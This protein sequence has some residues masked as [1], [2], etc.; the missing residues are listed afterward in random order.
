MK[1]INVAIIGVGS[2]SKALV[3]G[4]SFYTKNPNE[5]TGLINPT[6]GN[7]KIKDINFVS[8]LPAYSPPSSSPEGIET[9]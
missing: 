1:I 4:V 3:E 2:M 7:Y 6:I 8:I 9:V 5:T